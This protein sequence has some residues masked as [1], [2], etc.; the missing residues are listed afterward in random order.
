MFN[1]FSQ[2]HVGSKTTEQNMSIQPLCP[3]PL[4]ASPAPVWVPCEADLSALIERARASFKMPIKAGQLDLS[5]A[6]LEGRLVLAIRD[7]SKA[8]RANENPGITRT[9]LQ[10]IAGPLGYD[11]VN[12][13]CLHA[14]VYYEF[15]RSR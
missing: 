5:A 11:L 1:I 12:T 14:R 8:A 10:H 6:I 7:G 9:L 13:Q 2:E 4:K 15:E 3:S